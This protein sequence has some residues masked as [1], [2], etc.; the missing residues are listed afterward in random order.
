MNLFCFTLVRPVMFCTP[1]PSEFVCQQHCVSRLQ[2]WEAGE[3]QCA[4]VGDSAEATVVDKHLNE[5]SGERHKPTNNLLLSETHL[6]LDT[7]SFA[8]LFRVARVT[9]RY[10]CERVVMILI[11]LT[12]YFTVFL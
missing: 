6:F 2:P 4:A 1:V 8:Q 7:S 3:T 11:L 12:T 9:Y 5:L 10:K